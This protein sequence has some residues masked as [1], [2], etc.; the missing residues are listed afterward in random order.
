MNT[1]HKLLTLIFFIVICIPAFSQ[2]PVQKPD[3]VTF[4]S[5]NL[6][7]KGLLWKPAGKGPFP[8]VMYN[9][10]SEARPEKFLTKTPF[11]FL[12]HG[13]AFFAPCRRGQGLSKDQGKYIIDQ[14]DSAGLAGG[15]DARFSLAIKLHETSQLQDQMAA[16]AFLKSQPGIDAGRIALIGISFGGI[17]TMLMAERADGIKAALNF[18]GA[19]MMWEKSPEVAAWLQKG[20]ADVKVPIYFIQAENDFSIK[21]SLVLSEE[22]KKLG[23]PYALKIY[24]PRGTTP[25]EGHTLIDAEEIWT[26]DVFPQLDKW[27]DKR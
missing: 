12:K 9:H 21:P 17:Q 18:A 8:A 20:V 3:T 5:G 27:M 6:R 24:P 10:G 23:K 4:Q 16:L 14:L 11:A 26:P 13:Y 1:Q 19:A 15:R 22:M 25:M 7:L 2:D